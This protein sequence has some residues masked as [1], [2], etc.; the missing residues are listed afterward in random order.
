MQAASAARNAKV[1][2]PTRTT[3][4]RRVQS[5]SSHH[6]T[7]D[8]DMPHLIHRD[9]VAIVGEDGRE[10]AR[11]LV[12]YDAAETERVQ[13]V[14]SSQIEAILGYSGGPTLIHAD[15]LALIHS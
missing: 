7:C 2:K 9:A 12:R 15:D 3:K 4:G 5:E 8:K 1:D 10:F 14:K 13:G 11:G 6:G